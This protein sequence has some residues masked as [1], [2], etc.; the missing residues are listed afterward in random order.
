MYHQRRNHGSHSNEREG[1]PSFSLKLRFNYYV[2]NIVA[3]LDRFVQKYNSEEM[4]TLYVSIITE[5]LLLY[6]ITSM[7]S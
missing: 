7:L 3:K 2:N 6:Y 5:S 1:K 4:N